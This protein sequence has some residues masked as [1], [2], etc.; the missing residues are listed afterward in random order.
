MNKSTQQKELSEHNFDFITALTHA[1]IEKLLKQ[2]VFQL[3]LFDEELSEVITEHNRYILKRNPV[4]AEEINQNRKSKISKLEQIITERNNYL[5]QHTL[6]K[7]STALKYCNDKLQRMNLQAWNQL[8]SDDKLR[9]IS[10]VTDKDKLL[11]LSRLDGCYCLT[12]SLTANEYNKE[13]VHSR[14]KDL[15]MVENAFRTCKTG[16]LE[17]RPIYVR[18]KERTRGHVFVVMLSYMLIQ[19]LRACWG[20]LDMTVEEG[21][22][23]LETLCTVQVQLDGNIPALY[24]P[25]P[26]KE[27]EQLFT[28]ANIPIP[29]IF[30]TKLKTNPNTKTKLKNVACKQ[31]TKK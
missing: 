10:I 22:E 14:Y 17:L 3:S 16:Q 18:K 8:E 6:A 29:E 15:A 23:L 13:F 24:V 1:Q 4:R 5:S 11:E 25:K 7:L 31:N 9:T 19:K 21:I 30:P 26:R 2:N 28:L 20:E 12:T 27:I